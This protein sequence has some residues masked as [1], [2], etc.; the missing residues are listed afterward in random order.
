MLVL[1]T[2]LSLYSTYVFI[3]AVCA[4][5]VKIPNS[6]NKAMREGLCSHYLARQKAGEI[7]RVSVRCSKFRA[8][9]DLSLSPVIMVNT[10]LYAINVVTG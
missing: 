9:E 4:P 6:E 7:V 2:T 1:S 8:P 5:K 3:L 10:V